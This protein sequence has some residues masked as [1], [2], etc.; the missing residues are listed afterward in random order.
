MP[1]KLKKY[2]I[3][4]WGCQMN[5]HDAEL[6]AGMLEKEGYTYTDDINQCDLV[7]LITCCVRENAEAKVFGRIGRL[8]QLKREKPDLI[9]AVGG[10]M[11]QQEPVAQQIARQF[12]YVDLVFGTHNM[13][14]FPQLLENAVNSKQTYVEVL[15]TPGGIIE[16]LPVRRTERLKAWVNITYGCNNYC[17][18]CIVPYVRGRERSREP[19][20]ILNE[21]HEL[22][23]NGYLEVTLLGQNVNSYGIDLGREFTFPDLL[24][25]IDGIDGSLKRLRFMTSHPKD[26]SPQLINVIAEGQ[27]TCE[28]IHLPVQ[29]GS[30]H[31]LKKMNRKYTRRHYL[32]LIEQI[33]LGI[34]DVSITTD[35]IVGFP[36]ETEADFEDTLD[37]IRKVEFDAAFTFIYSKRSGTPAAAMPEQV[38]ESVKK[39]RLKRLMELQND[40]SKKKNFLLKGKT[41]EVLVEG[42][43]KNNENKLIGRTRANKIVHMDGDA[44]CIGKFRSVII[45]NPKTWT[46]EGELV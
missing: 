18:Y 1:Y 14:Q 45:T 24:R 21:I 16:G 31:I 29:S 6:L 32:N 37:I 3:I 19:K 17:S 2:H 41:L 33:K 28:H 43:S 36:G 34:P 8:K 20:D 38:E 5:E 23:E 15:D 13:T 44:S 9:I 10:C 4:V 7:I 46:L 11:T 30:D 22:S 40:I 12:P 39:D 35:I 42:F 25:K 26:F 27:K